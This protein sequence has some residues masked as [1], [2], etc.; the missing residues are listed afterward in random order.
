MLKQILL[1]AAFAVLVSVA[2][3][4]AADLGFAARYARAF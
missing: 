1:L 2:N 3:E 4:Y